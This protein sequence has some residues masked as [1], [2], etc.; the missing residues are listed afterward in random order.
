[1]LLMTSV[2]I[3]TAPSLSVSLFLN[4]KGLPVRSRCWMVEIDELRSASI[5][6][7]PALLPYSLLLNLSR[8][9][10]ISGGLFWMIS[11]KRTAKLIRD[12]SL[13]SYIRINSRCWMWVQLYAS[14]DTT[15]SSRGKHYCFMS[16]MIIFSKLPSLRSWLAI[17]SK[18]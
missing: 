3:S 14:L 11:R 9:R 13:R 8:L 17:K 7:S 4:H 18:N 15:S 2:S 6:I 10:C 5:M 12:S 1:M 16:L